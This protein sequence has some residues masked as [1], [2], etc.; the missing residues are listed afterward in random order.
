MDKYENIIEDAGEMDIYAL[1]QACADIDK[2]IGYIRKI[3]I[4]IPSIVEEKM[5]KLNENRK[6]I[7]K[8]LQS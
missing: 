8:Y 2:T 7:E 4:K 1:G 6:R 5:K 3:V